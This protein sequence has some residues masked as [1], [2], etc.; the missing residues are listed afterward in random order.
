[1]DGVT[2]YAPQ[3]LLALA[4]G[5]SACT[6]AP[7]AP[8]KARGPASQLDRLAFEDPRGSGEADKRVRKLQDLLKRQPKKVDAWIL[9][10]RAF[11]KKARQS[12]E[13]GFYNNAQACAKRAL[14]LRPQYSLALDLQAMV[15][16][17]QHRFSEAKALTQQVL[18]R[19]PDDLLALGTLAD[20]TLELGEVQVALKAV[21]NMGDLKPSLP[22]YA[23]VAHLRWLHGDIEG[24]K[25][26]YLLAMDCGRGAKDM[27]PFAWVVSE[28]ALVFLKEGDVEAAEIGFNRAL[29][30]H[31]DYPPAL[32]GLG[33]VAMARGQ[34][35]KAA[36]QLKA[37]FEGSALAQ[38]AWL[39]NEAEI[40]AGRVQP[41]QAARDKALRL[42]RHGEGRV[43]ARMLA[44]ENLGLDEA[45]KSIA[46]ELKTRGDHVTHGISAFVKYRQGDLR[47]ARIALDEALKL[48]TPE[49][50][51]WAQDGLIKLAEGQ[52]KLGR[53]RLKKALASK[54]ALAPSMV[55]E[56]QSALAK[57]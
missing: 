41:A 22:T 29:E 48:G 11:V 47:G 36:G 55:V 28:A 52:T 50:T 4:L 46:V 16:M 13:P 43:L 20:A 15:L 12:T 37:S 5:M 7:T 38:T 44:A 39:W 35:V 19:D 6:P 10:G 18:E 25:Q 51:L 40:K 54:A 14:D 27:E 32:R 57:S 24:A 26:A 34:W 49:P 17:N 42:G 9:L 23:R 53:A 3:A 56:I 45:A 1:M 30:A 31:A 21:E 8:P 33:Q 2:K